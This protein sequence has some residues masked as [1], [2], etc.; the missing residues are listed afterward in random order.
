VTASAASLADRR[1]PPVTELGAAAMAAIAGGVVYEAAYLPKHAPSAPAVVLLAMAAAIELACWLLLGRVRDFAWWRFL[2]V[3]RYGL[4]AY[5]VIGGM[6]EYAF[7]YDHTRGTQLVLLTLLLALF[8]LD[9]PLLMAF[10][11][12]RYQRAAR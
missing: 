2:E 1:L 12:A 7:L 9:V 10:T 4:A 6:I 11:V 3:F 5:V 8:V